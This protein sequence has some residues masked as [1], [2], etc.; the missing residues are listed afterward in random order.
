LQARIPDAPSRRYPLIEQPQRLRLNA[1]DAF[2]PDLHGVD[3]AIVL[4][5]A[6]PPQSTHFLAIVRQTLN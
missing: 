3:Q 1:T 2:A 5:R 6:A 4:V